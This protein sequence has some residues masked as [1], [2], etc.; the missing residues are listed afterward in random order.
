MFRS[1]ILPLVKSV[2]CQTCII[3]TAASVIMHILA[4]TIADN[5]VKLEIYGIL[6]ILLIS[7]LIALCNIVF[8]VRALPLPLKLLIHF[9]VV[10]SAVVFAFFA[11]TPASASSRGAIVLVSAIAA[12]Y[13]VAAVIM[14]IVTGKIRRK[15]SDSADYKPQF[16]AVTKNDRKKR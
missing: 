5:S 3:F 16:E 4:G 8:R 11:L 13:A 1:K 15:E 9:L 7:F 12:V 2:I 10:T 14:I 6:T